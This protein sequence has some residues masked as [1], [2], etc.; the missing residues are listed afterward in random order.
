MGRRIV[1]SEKRCLKQREQAREAGIIVDCKKENL[2]LCKEV[3]CCAV[4]EAVQ[5]EKDIASGKMDKDYSASSLVFESGEL[6]EMMSGSK[7]EPLG[8]F[9]Q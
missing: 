9:Q 7:V 2:K 6:N 3:K 1:F 8:R 5:F 4:E